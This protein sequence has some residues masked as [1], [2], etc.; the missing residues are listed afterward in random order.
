MNRYGHE[1]FLI[2]TPF[3]SFYTVSMGATSNTNS[4]SSLA[5]GAGSTEE[6]CSKAHEGTPPPMRTCIAE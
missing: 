5:L 1:F 6:K 4:E 2:I 3:S